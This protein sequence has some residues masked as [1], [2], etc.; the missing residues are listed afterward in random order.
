MSMSAVGNWLRGDLAQPSAG[1]VIAF[2]RAF[3]QPPLEALTAAGY[4]APDEAIPTARTPL[5]E[6]SDLELLD[7]LRRRSGGRGD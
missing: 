3:R 4:F 7:E 1:S 6:Y 5:A 2:A